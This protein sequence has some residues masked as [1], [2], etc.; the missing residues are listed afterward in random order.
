MN[1]NEEL[2]IIEE[3]WAHLKTK[4]PS[5]VIYKNNINQCVY[6]LKNKGSDEC[7]FEIDNLFFLFKNASLNI[8]FKMIDVCR[9]IYKNTLLK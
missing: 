7:Q 4:V 6:N 1:Q 3:V 9:T 2:V 8:V 5:F